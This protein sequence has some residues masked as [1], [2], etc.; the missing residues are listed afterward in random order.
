MAKVLGESGKYVSQEAVR[1][2]RNLVALAIASMPI[3]GFILGLQ[4]GNTLWGG[5]MSPWTRNSLCAGCVLAIGA[6]GVWT[7]RRMDVPEKQRMDCQRAADGETLVAMKL[8]AFPDDFHVIHDLNTKFGNFDH[9][10][11]GPTGVF[12]LENKNWKG[13]VSADGNDELLLNGKPT[14]APFVRRF[15]ARILDVKEKVKTLTN[16]LDPYIQAVFVFPSAK[17]EA[18]WGTTRSV[19]CMD[20]DRLFRYILENNTGKNLTKQGVKTITRAFSALAC[21]DQDFTA[22]A[23]PNGQIYLAVDSSRHH[24][25]EHYPIV[26]VL[27]KLSRGRS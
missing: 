16:G 2:R 13:V 25:T 21:M 27:P 14:D 19:L 12:I 4:F 11:V 23:K 7:C 10:I 17:V 1:K 20:S 18:R 8:D 22:K 24:N 15:L 5:R 6:I 26:P 9:I 3:L